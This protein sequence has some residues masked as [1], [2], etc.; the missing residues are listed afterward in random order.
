[1]KLAENI[2][3]II[4]VV[5]ALSTFVFSQE[6]I[7]VSTY[8]IKFLN[9]NVTSQGN[10]LDKLRE[11]ITRLDARIIGLQEIKNRAA[12]QLIFPPQE[13]QIIIDDDSGDDQ[14]VALVVKKPLR[15]LGVNPDL[16]T[17]DQNFLFPSSTDNSS[18]P[19]RRDVA[20]RQNSFQVLN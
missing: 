2:L 18:F 12:L 7:R 13:W 20:V 15:I 17:D 14:N 3:R 16:D 19:N 5:L 8:N 1:M 9:T 11:V 6:R 4:V 10:R